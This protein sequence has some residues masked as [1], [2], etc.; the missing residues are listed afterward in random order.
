LLQNCGNPY[1][2]AC[3]D[4][5][6]ISHLSQRFAGFG[7]NTLGQA[8]RLPRSQWV[9]PPLARRWEVPAYPHNPADA[10]GETAMVNVYGVFLKPSNLINLITHIKYL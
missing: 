10:G 7:G 4:L 3:G 9:S 1:E 2:Q 5:R 6:H 8:Q